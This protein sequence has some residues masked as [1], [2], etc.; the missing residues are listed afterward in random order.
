MVSL[1]NMN[2]N[3]LEENALMYVADMSNQNISN[4]KMVFCGSVSFVTITTTTTTTTTP[5]CSLRRTA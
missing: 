3:Q 4:R 2:F 5:F 1:F